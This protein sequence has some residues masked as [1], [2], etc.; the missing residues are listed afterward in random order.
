MLLELYYRYEKTL[1]RY[2]KNDADIAHFICWLE[3]ISFHCNGWKSWGA[4]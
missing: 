2:Y 3:D 1:L 4:A